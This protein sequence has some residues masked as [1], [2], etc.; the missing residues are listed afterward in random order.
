MRPSRFLL[1]TQY[2]PPEAG[3]ASVRLQSMVRELVARGHEVDVVTALP[4]YP[5]GRIFEGYR[6]RLVVTEQ[7]DGARVRRVWIHTATGSGIGRALM[8]I[9]FAATSTLAMLF[10][11]RPTVVLVE[12]PPL[13]ATVG[14][15]I[16]RLV[17]R[18][19]TVLLLADLWPDTAAEL[20]LVRR[21]SALFRVLE[22]LERL[23]YRTSWRVSPVTD[24]Q[25]ETLRSEKGVPASRIAFLPNGVDTE[26]FHP[27]RPQGSSSEHDRRTILFAGT[28]GY[29][30]GLDVLL[31]AA[32]LVLA[33][34]PDARF[35]LVGGGS[36]S[37]RLRRRVHD[38]AISG[39]E[40]KDPV[41]VDAVAPYFRECYVGVSTIRRL[42]MLEDARPAKIFP[43]MASGRPVVYSGRGEGATLVSDADAGLVV[44]PEDPVAL[45]GALNRLLDDPELARR[46]GGN[47]R[48]LVE[49]EYS[50]SAL[51]DSWLE[52]LSFDEIA[53]G[54]RL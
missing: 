12:S 19:P 25:V 39:V 14:A 31:D 35:L 13:T 9:T 33:R 16:H 17:R 30:H 49:A 23:V 24:G 4:N 34:H 46:L 6:G 52:N 11:R 5:T 42:E 37:E 45:A 43:I 53:D 38:E 8:F 15:L 22:R 32:P 18:T 50:W 44:E 7:R 47:G 2:Y 26:L 29:A 3:A 10:N 54:G 21:D 40:F 41:S 36:D 27:A 48:R 1:L 20:G 28:L 51:I